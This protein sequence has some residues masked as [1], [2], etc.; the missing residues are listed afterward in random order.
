M[1]PINT[2]NILSLV[3]ASTDTTG[4]AEELHRARHLPLNHECRR[5]IQI[6]R[7]DTLSTSFHVVNL[8]REIKL[9]NKKAACLAMKWPLLTHRHPPCG[10]GWC[11]PQVVWAYM[12]PPLLPGCFRLGCPRLPNVQTLSRGDSCLL[13]HGRGRCSGAGLGMVQGRFSYLAHHVSFSGSE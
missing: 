11:L 13:G 2:R 3:T 9:L 1:L 12:S 6:R 5:F 10:F 4:H 8:F 7:S